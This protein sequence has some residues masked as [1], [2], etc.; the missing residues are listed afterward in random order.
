MEHF[1]LKTLEDLPKMEEFSR[2]A[3]EKTGEEL[4]GPDDKDKAEAIN[5]P[6]VSA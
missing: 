6:S 5:E 1:G 3:G 2:I 4:N